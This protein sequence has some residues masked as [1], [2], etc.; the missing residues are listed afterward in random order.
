MVV[1]VLSHDQVARE[2]EGG[3]HRMAW[4]VAGELQKKAVEEAEERRRL[5]H[6]EVEEPVGQLQVVGEVRARLEDCVAQEEEAAA[7]DRTTTWDH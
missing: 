2:A 7:V 3:H 4:E 6:P 5:T 1:R